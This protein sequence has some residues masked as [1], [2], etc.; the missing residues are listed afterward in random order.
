[1]SNAKQQ[2]QNLN[3]DMTIKSPFFVSFFHQSLVDYGVLSVAKKIT[4]LL[5]L[6]S[7][8]YKNLEIKYNCKKLTHWTF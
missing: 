8:S 3:L 2:R 4:R 1:M 6:L 5:H 7:I